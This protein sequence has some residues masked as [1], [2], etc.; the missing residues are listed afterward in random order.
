MATNSPVTGS[1]DVSPV[2]TSRTH[3]PLERR[4][5]RAML[6]DGGST[7]N[8]IFAL[9]NARSCMIFEARNWSHAPID[10][11]HLAVSGSG[12]VS[13]PFDV[14]ARRAQLLLDA[15]HAETP[16][17]LVNAWDV[18]SRAPASQRGFRLW[19]PRA[20]PS[21]KLSASPTT[22]RVILFLSSRTSHG[23]HGRSRFRHGRPRGRFPSSTRRIGR[24]PSRSGS[25]RL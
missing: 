11:R 5:R 21:P 1:V 20:R 15:H 18:P 25:R 7:A 22:T 16:L 2:S 10:R 9:A 4:C 3:D 8:S 14:L 17:L 19:R 23:S 12:N 13:A 6:D 24:A